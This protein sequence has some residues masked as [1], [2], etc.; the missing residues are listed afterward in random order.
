MVNTLCSQILQKMFY[1]P[2][3][4]QSK[5]KFQLE[6][7]VIIALCRQMITIL[8]KEPTLVRFKPPAKIFGSIHGQHDDL[9]RMFE[10]YGVPDSIP[11]FGQSDIEAVGYVFLGNYVDRGKNSLEVLCT[12][13]SL[14]LKYPREIVLLRGAHEDRF[15]N[16]NEGLGTECE[17]RLSE[18]INS[19]SSVFS[20]INE[21]FDHL[22]L[23]CLLGQKVLCVPSGI[24]E[25]I[26]SIEQIKT[27]KRPITISH[28]EKLSLEEKLVLDL[29][30]SDPVQDLDEDSN[31]FNEQRSYIAHG[32][33]IKYGVKRIKTFMASNNIDVLIRSHEPV[34]DGVEKFG[35]TNLYTVFSC[36]NY[37]GTHQNSAAL[38]HFK[39]HKNQLKSLSIEPQ[40]NSTHWFSFD[41]LKKSHLTRS[42]F[43]NANEDSGIDL[44]GPRDTVTPLRKFKDKRS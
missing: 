38:L 2:N 8:K 31:Q 7:K 19:S 23:A 13:F 27:I 32:N 15:I 40:E 34:K 25:H 24:G 22:P 1:K 18:N 6:S 12:L 36:S 4:E 5:K 35:D 39:K 29:L 44:M 20:K 17:N 30:W 37:G 26:K 21:V 28:A 10:K 14:K 16:I 41:K 42:V 33:V 43:M 9:L 11:G 3:P